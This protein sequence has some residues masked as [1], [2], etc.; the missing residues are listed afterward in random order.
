MLTDSSVESSSSISSD[1]S[2]DEMGTSGVW[3]EKERREVRTERGGRRRVETKRELTLVGER[4]NIVDETMNGD[5]RSVLGLLL[6]CWKQERGR[7]RVSSR[8]RKHERTGCDP[9]SSHETIGKASFS[10]G[11]L[12]ASAASTSFLSFMV[13]CPLAISLAGKVLR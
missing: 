2:L 6:D 11:H 12:R 4:G 9:Q 10:T 1:G 7:E 5:E 8:S 3:K 13:Y